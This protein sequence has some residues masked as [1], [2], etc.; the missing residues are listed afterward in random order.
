MTDENPLVL[1][2]DDAGVAT[3]TL[4]RPAARNALSH[5]MLRALRAAFD[6]IAADAAVRVVI[7]AGA[8]PGFCAGHDLK[9]VRANQDD[10]RFAEIG[11][12]HV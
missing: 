7:L 12:A 3:L 11:R 9:E 6:T 4:N 10:R 2:Q 8:G 1:R 5:A